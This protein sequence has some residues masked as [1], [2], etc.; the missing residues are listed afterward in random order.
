M[1]ASNR[2]RRCDALNAGIDKCTNLYRAGLHMQRM[3][4]DARILNV[5]PLLDCGVHIV[6]L[7]PRCHNEIETPTL[8]IPPMSNFSQLYTNPAVLIVLAFFRRL[9]P[10]HWLLSSPMARELSPPHQ[11]I[12]R[13]YSCLYG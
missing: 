8:T 4:W 1:S 5:D 10:S 12:G 11:F 3:L 13:G 2:K 9:A 7:Y 6:P